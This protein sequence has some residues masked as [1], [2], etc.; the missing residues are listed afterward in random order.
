MKI[1]KNLK[2]PAMKLICY[3]TILSIGLIGC[4][5]GNN[6]SLDKHSSMNQTES[7]VMINGKKQKVSSSPMD[8]NDNV[9][10]AIPN[11]DGTL[12]VGDGRTTFLV[13]NDTSHSFS[14]VGCEKSDG[15]WITDKAGIN[16]DGANSIKLERNQMVASIQKQSTKNL[17]Q[18]KDHGVSIGADLK[19]YYKI[20][21]KDIDK[22]LYVKLNFKKDQ[23]AT[24]SAIFQT[25]DRPYKEMAQARRD[26]TPGWFT[27]VVN[28]VAPV[29]G[30]GAR[31]AVI[32]SLPQNVQK[33]YINFAVDKFYN[34]LATF[35]TLQF[36]N[37]NSQLA[38]IRSLPLDKQEA[39]FS[40]LFEEMTSNGGQIYPCIQPK[41]ISKAEAF[42]Y[43]KK[44]DHYGNAKLPNGEMSNRWA[45]LDK[46]GNVIGE[47][48]SINETS[49]ISH[50]TEAQP[51]MEKEIEDSSSKLGYDMK[52]LKENL[53]VREVGELG[54]VGLSEKMMERGIRGFSGG[55]QFSYSMALEDINI[56]KEGSH[57]LPSF[58]K[59]AS[60]MSSIETTS[61]TI[62]EDG[63][64][65][66]IYDAAEKE[67]I[68]LAR[69]EMISA[70]LSSTGVGLLVE[71]VSWFSVFPL[72]SSALFPGVT[73]EFT[74]ALDYGS[75]SVPTPDDI[76]NWNKQHPDNK[77]ED[78]TYQ[79]GLSKSTYKSEL[80]IAAKPNSK[81]LFDRSDVIKIS[82]DA[83]TTPFSRSTTQGRDIYDN[84]IT[85][86]D[87]DGNSVFMMTIG[88]VGSNNLATR[89]F[90]QEINKQILNKYNLG[91]FM[92]S[93]VSAPVVNK[94]MMTNYTG[95]LKTSLMNSSNI[96][97]A[98]SG[99]QGLALKK[100]G[101]I[102]GLFIQPNQIV[103]LN[104]SIPDDT[105]SDGNGYSLLYVSNKL[106][107]SQDPAI[108]KIVKSADL[109]D[110]SKSL[111]DN[112]LLAMFDTPFPY[113]LSD[114][115]NLSIAISDGGLNGISSSG[116]LYVGDNFGETV[117]IP[118]YLNYA[119]LA[120]PNILSAKKNGG[121]VSFTIANVTDKDYSNLEITGIPE[122]A[123][124]SN[125]ALDSLK[126][127]QQRK[128]IIDL[129]DV[130]KIGTY[131]IVIKGI[132]KNIKLNDIQHVSLTVTKG[133]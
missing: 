96:L 22:N 93:L 47:V 3:T 25:V 81:E 5:G 60:K 128:I 114:S 30:I 100:V 74:T 23:Y 46:E 126:A 71:A 106:L 102:Q 28:T 121:K 125:G 21:D 112:V 101:D 62:L 70:V 76:N 68:G 15:N 26:S 105:K 87:T 107:S 72:L 45:P 38:R 69:R 56:A 42:D 79:V 86:L 117:E 97:Q 95:S 18:I 77:I 129:S 37:V 80:S 116:H 55:G 91:N 24:Y 59:Y 16:L 58:E 27:G 120:E 85:D 61:S 66:F 8:D 111:G 41:G 127:G 50:W 2:K 20:Y 1:K 19:C 65:K 92:P 6:N 33:E 29:A 43:F 104:L 118:V 51:M 64:T 119:L 130:D 32:A 123:E 88:A 53:S 12:H 48:R 73:G 35:Q 4:E 122:D 90:S 78:T 98:N 54:D 14:L 57:V 44:V 89:D 67:F 84:D 75:L 31:A 39:E 131:D 36:E 82:L 83:L 108:Y 99:K 94:T 132:S 34:D 109:F 17:I 49:G 133:W 115:T 103:T 113:K 11:T 9:W 13:K 10:F 40:K 63:E 52:V 110:R 7:Y 124:L